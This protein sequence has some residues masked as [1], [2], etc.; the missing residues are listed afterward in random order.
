MIR[1]LVVLTC[2]LALLAPG[3]AHAQESEVVSLLRDLVR[4][5]TSNPPG[6]EALVAELLRPRLEALG[7]QVEIVPT[8][9]PG[10]SHLIAR[11][12]AT[13]RAEKPLL[14]AG[15]ADVVGVEQPLWTVDPFGGVVAGERLFGRG[16][17]DF[18]G[19][20]AAFTVAAMRLARAGVPRTAGPDPARRSRRGGRRLRHD[21]AGREPLAEDR[22]RDSINE[23][24]WIF[25]G[26]RGGAG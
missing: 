11:L 18:K 26:G 8:P 17:M 1:R 7:F 16:A 19:G 3:V 13:A 23:G 6:N 5:N 21:L 24:G 10:K 9:A 25:A 4:V 14:L 15:H 22:R 20:L 12:P 2:A